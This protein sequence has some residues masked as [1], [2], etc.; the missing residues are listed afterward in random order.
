MK[1]KPTFILLVGFKSKSQS[2][3]SSSLLFDDFG[4]K[5]NEDQ[6]FKASSCIKEY[7]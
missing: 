2:E 5:V 3:C 6:L 7:M 1:A 4:K